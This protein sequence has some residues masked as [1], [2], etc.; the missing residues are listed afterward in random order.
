MNIGRTH[1]SKQVFILLIAAALI[2]VWDLFSDHGGI[3]SGTVSVMVVALTALLLGSMYMGG[4]HHKDT[5]P[6]EPQNNPSPSIEMEETIALLAQN[7]ERES[8]AKLN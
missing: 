2:V 7:E 8:K 5:N 1:V 4:A 3:K 6:P